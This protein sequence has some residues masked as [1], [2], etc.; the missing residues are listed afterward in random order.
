MTL[1]KLINKC[2]KERVTVLTYCEAAGP[3]G[4]GIIFYKVFPDGR[5]RK[6]EMTFDIADFLLPGGELALDQR[7]EERLE[8]LRREYDKVQKEV[9]DAQTNI[10]PLICNDLEAQHD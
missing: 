8:T 5:T 3:F 7:I 9:D 2:A 6:I 1:R 10:H 4:S